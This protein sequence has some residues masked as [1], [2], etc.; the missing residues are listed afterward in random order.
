MQPD[1]LS[2][3]VS[4]ILADHENE[5]WLSPISVWELTLLCR[6]KR[7]RVHSDVS[8][9]VADSVAQLRIIEA[10][11][12]LEV[13]LAIPSISLPHGDPA[14]HFLAASA[15]VFGLILVTADATLLATPGLKVLA[16]R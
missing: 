3:R 1:R 9:W 14:D 7:L 6:K 10:P 12:T 4:K 15:K 2:N 13:A 5:L 11:L 16:N 8:T